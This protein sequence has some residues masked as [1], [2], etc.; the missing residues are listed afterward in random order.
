MFVGN[1]NIRARCDGWIF[2]ILRVGNSR[3]ACNGLQ[4][5][6]IQSTKAALCSVEQELW[7]SVQLRLLRPRT[8]LPVGILCSQYFKLSRQSGTGLL[9][10]WRGRG[11]ACGSAAIAASS[12]REALRA[13]AQPSPQIQSSVNA[14]PESTWHPFA[15]SLASSSAS[16]LPRKKRGGPEAQGDDLFRSDVTLYLFN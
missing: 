1:S 13:M 14:V 12:V 6:W 5:D 3:A 15:V 9:A 7:H 2:D 8:C 10:I 11:G 4:G 16:A